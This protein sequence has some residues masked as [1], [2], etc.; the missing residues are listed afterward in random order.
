MAT[1]D[2]QLRR[3]TLREAMEHLAYLELR[4]SFR[5]DDESFLRA[6]AARIVGSLLTDN[7]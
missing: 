1:E 4:E 3:R 7:Y 2:K 5:E 6:V